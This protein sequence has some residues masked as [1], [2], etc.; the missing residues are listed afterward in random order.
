MRG[1]FAGQLA[2]TVRAERLRGR[3]RRVRRARRTVEDVIG[4]GIEHAGADRGAF[5]GHHSRRARIECL[6]AV[7][8]LL[9]EIDGGVASAKD[10]CVGSGARELRTHLVAVLDVEIPVGQR[11][12]VVTAGAGA[13]ND[14][15][16]EHPARAGDRELH[17]SSAGSRSEGRSRRQ[18][19]A[20]SLSESTGSAHGQGMSS[21]GSFHAIVRAASAR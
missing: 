6:G 21:C 8:L 1:R 18:E 17:A 20:A 13:Q 2:A 16:A 11:N 7:F 15:C 14:V 3:I 10:D 12:D 9:G 4:A 5:L 19:A